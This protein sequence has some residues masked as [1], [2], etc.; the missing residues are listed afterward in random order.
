MF[1]CLVFKPDS[2]YISVGETYQEFRWRRDKF[3]LVL[4][5]ICHLTR[6]SKLTRMTRKN[7]KSE[8]RR[9]WFW[10]RQKIGFPLSWH[11]LKIFFGSIN[12]V[13]SIGR[14]TAFY[15][16]LVP[17]ELIPSKPPMALTS[18]FCFVLC[19]KVPLF[20]FEILRGVKSVRKY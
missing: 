8:E 14:L 4:T 1:L 10:V 15:V 5:G 3:S 16:L 7:P 18:L 19:K 13:V 2:V 9:K 17:M 6:T 12:L 20:S 11:L